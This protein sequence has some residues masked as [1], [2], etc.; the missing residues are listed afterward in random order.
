MTAVVA[1][2]ELTWAGKGRVC[3]TLCALPDATRRVGVVGSGL[4]RCGGGMLVGK[5][6]FDIGGAADPLGVPAAQARDIAVR[7]LLLMMEQL[8]VLLLMMGRVLHRVVGTVAL[9]LLMLVL[10]LALANGLLGALVSTIAARPRKD[11][12]DQFAGGAF[13]RRRGWSW[14]RSRS[15]SRSGSGSDRRR[16][17]ALAKAMAVAVAVGSGARRCLVLGRGNGSR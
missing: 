13:L 9:R 5:D 14:S 11:A 6:C 3:L 7:S 16:Y 15:R 10:G 4:G 12:L 8:V 1:V 2:V 17:V